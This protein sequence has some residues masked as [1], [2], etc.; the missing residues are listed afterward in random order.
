MNELTLEKIKEE[1]SNELV[2]KKFGKIF[3][4][5]RLQLAIDFRAPNAKF[6][7]ISLEPAAPRIYLINRR[8]RDLEKL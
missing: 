6:L 7:F 2:G 4:L 5:T 8:L 3:P 1:I